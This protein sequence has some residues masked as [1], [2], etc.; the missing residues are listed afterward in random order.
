MIN[1]NNINQAKCKG[2]IYKYWKQHRRIS[3]NTKAISDFLTSVK[4]KLDWI[5]GHSNN[6]WTSYV[7]LSTYLITTKRALRRYGTRSMGNLTKI[8]MW[9][10][11]ALIDC[12]PHR[13]IHMQ[14][15]NGSLKTRT[16]IRFYQ[17]N[18]LLLKK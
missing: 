1:H 18:S 3:E 10:T 17:E 8:R 2:R 14:V 11:D 16:K 7:S 12:L 5:P 4:Y 15:L 6:E 13:L 9:C